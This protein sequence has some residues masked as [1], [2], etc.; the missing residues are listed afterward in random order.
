MRRLASQE[1][2]KYAEDDDEDYD[3]VF[4]KTNGS[5]AYPLF[6]ILIWDVIGFANC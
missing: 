5:C 1:F 2:N 6:L 4:G 3:D